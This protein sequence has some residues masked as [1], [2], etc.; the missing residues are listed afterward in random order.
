MTYSEPSPEQ[1]LILCVEDEKHL[2][3]NIAEEL[4]DAGYAV[5]EADDGRAALA[6]LE[7]YRP[8]LV[9]CDI[10]MPRMGGYELL[11][12]VRA[13]EPGLANMPFVFL[14]ALSDRV[15]V[16]DGKSAGAD[17]Y[18]TKP[19]DF[20]LM[21]AT[22]RSR[23]DQVTRIETNLNAVAENQRVLEVSQALRRGMS[24]LKMA[25]SHVSMGVLLFDANKDVTYRNTQSEAVLGRGLTIVNNKLSVKVPAEANLMRAALTAAVEQGTNS[26]FLTVSQAD[27]HPLIIQVISLGEGAGPG[28][29]RAAAFL[30]DTNAPPPI[31]EKLV[32]KL[33]GFTPTEARVAT[34]IARG[35]HTNEVVLDM[36]ITSTT[37]AFH[38]RNIFR[39]A[40][41]SR[42][43]DLV[44]LLARSAV[45]NQVEDLARSATD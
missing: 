23:L 45:V 29:T 19:I 17:D 38:L 14:T 28:A 22:I 40:Q 36:G 24:D 26:D 7:T 42:Q 31:S 37:F 10:T 18:L 39:K 3:T 2:R 41:V 33:Y 6:L 25:L 44:A 15:A 20:D 30:I 34:A 11:R 9:L 43:Q 13:R 32:A 8:H 21:L 12:E 1:V 16:I 27:D 5:I 4:R 35:R